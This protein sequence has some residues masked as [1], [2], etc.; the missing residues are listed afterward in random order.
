MTEPLALVLALVL[1]LLVGVRGG[2]SL[3]LRL[4]RQRRADLRV[5]GRLS[6]LWPAE[7]P[8]RSPADILAGVVHVRLG[9]GLYELPVLS[10][11]ASRRWLERLDT[12]FALFADQVAAAG[13]DTPTI[14]AMLV[15]ETDGLY[16]L[17]QSY[18]AA[19]ANVLPPL[20]DIDDVATDTEIV[21]AILEVWRAVDPKAAGLSGPGASSI[22]G[23][24]P[25]SPTTPPGPTGGVPSAS[26]P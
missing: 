26:L 4:E 10:R 6:R 15:A 12:R 1:G 8:A 25:A 5:S 22:S 16:E 20:A 7:M 18:D 19:G 24:S 9:G 17:L 2:A 14:M 11:S 3:A 21:R 13:L 23:I